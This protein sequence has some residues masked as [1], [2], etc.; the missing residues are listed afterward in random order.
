MLG[1][2]KDLHSYSFSC[3]NHQFV[4]VLLVPVAALDNFD[5]QGQMMLNDS[6]AYFF[7][8]QIGGTTLASDTLTYVDHVI[9]KV[10]A[11]QK[12]TAQ[13]H[14][15]QSFQWGSSSYRLFVT[16]SSTYFQES[17]ILGDHQFLLS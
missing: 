14:L 5:L 8:V 16:G 4:S 9:S 13:V 7:V 15:A 3:P 10:E 12:I 2:P 1:D 11:K 6:F 17:D